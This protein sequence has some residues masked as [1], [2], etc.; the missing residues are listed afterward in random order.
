MITQEHLRNHKPF[1]FTVTVAMRD[2]IDYTNDRITE[3]DIVSL[4]ESLQLVNVVAVRAEPEGT[5]LLP[6]V[7]I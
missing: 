3:S 4:L 1:T 5:T 6:R 7:S 2:D